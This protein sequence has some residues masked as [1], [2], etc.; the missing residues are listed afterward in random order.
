MNFTQDSFIFGFF[1][2]M[3]GF[4][5]AL[6]LTGWVRAIL[7]RRAVFDIPNNRSSHTIPMPRGGGWALLAIMVPV[8][9]GTAVV[10]DHDARHAGLIIAVFLLAGVSWLDDRRHVS[11]AM[12]LS[13][14]ILAACLGTF[15]FG[16]HAMMLNG[17]V[18]FWLDR[19]LMILAWA[20]F[21]NMYNFMDGIDGITGAETIC[22]TTGLCIVCVAAGIDDPFLQFASLVV[23]GVCLGFLAHN[24]HPARIFLGDVGSVPLGYLCGFFLLSLAVNGHLAPA[25]ILPLYYLADTGITLIRRLNRGEKIWKAHREHFY[26]KAALGAGRHDTIVVMV[27]TANAALILAATLSV[28]QPL[29]AFAFGVVIVSILLALMYK[30]SFKHKVA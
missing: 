4:F 6:A 2:L 24:W 22:I 3:A 8:L 13:I 27:I 29:P 1:S 16:P 17:I 23:T 11:V 7:I 12:R 28:F 20:W 15:S 9:L 5:L 19:T 30:E 10:M 25:V 26:Q 21:I 18:P 14:H